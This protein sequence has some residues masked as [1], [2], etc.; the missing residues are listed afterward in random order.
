[1]ES[2]RLWGVGGVGTSPVA[3]GEADY[4]EQLLCYVRNHRIC[5]WELGRFWLCSFLDDWS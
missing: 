4:V 1:M 2:Q 5:P 3:F